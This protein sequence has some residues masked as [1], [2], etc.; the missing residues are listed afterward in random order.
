METR[1]SLGTLPAC[2]RHTPHLADAHSSFLLTFPEA[3][4]L[5][6]PVHVPVPVRPRPTAPHMGSCLQ[7]LPAPSSSVC[8]EPS[9]ELQMACTALV[10]PHCLWNDVKVP[11]MAF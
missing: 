8:S 11:D 2:S 4:C 10:A 3:L 7:F 5:P 1:E 6:V 9:P